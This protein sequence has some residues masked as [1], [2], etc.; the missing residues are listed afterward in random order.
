MVMKY[1]KTPK[2][3][4]MMKGSM[5]GHFKSERGMRQRDLMSPLLFVLNIEYLSRIMEKIGEREKLRFYENCEAIKLN[6]LSFVD[7]VL[8]FYHGVYLSTYSMLHCLDLFSRT[9][10]F[11]QNKGGN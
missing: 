10:G 5:H 3:S 6:H 4:L 7:D 11:Y 2:L 1:V 8:L 9:S